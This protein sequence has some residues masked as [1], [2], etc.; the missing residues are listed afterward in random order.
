MM[1]QRLAVAVILASATVSRCAPAL[2]GLGE[3]HVG[4]NSTNVA[5][6]VEATVAAASTSGASWGCGCEFPYDV[7]SYTTCY[8]SSYC[9]SSRRLGASEDGSPA[10]MKANAAAYNV[11]LQKQS[12]GSGSSGYAEWNCNCPGTYSYCSYTTCYYSC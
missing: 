3:V 9:G 11:S 5:S 8:Q 1:S 2:R 12:A 7:C 10:D 4:G 6:T